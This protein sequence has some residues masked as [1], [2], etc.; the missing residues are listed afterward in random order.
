L[1]VGVRL[2]EDAVNRAIPTVV[3][4]SLVLALALAPAA[5][6]APLT[7]SIIHTVQ[8][9]E[10]LF[11][12]GLKYGVSWADI[13]QANGLSSTYIYTGQQLTIPVAG[14]V[15]PS[16]AYT[17][18]GTYTVAWGDTL[19]SIAQRFGTTT[20]EL[21]SANNLRNSS[22]IFAGQTLN[23]PGGAAATEA[24]PAV[25][26]IPVVETP[27]EP[28]TA[29]EASVVGSY[30]VRTG[31]T[32]SAIAQRN[33][34]TTTALA[35][36]NGLP[37][38]AW[39]YAGQTLTIPPGGAEEAPAPIAQAAPAVAAIHAKEILVDISDQR[40]YAY[41]DGVLLYDFIAST[42]MAGRDT[43][44]GNYSVLN[45]IPNAYGATWNIWMPNWLGIYW[46]GS[47]QNGIHALPIL[48][49]GGRLW[50]GWLG[51]PVSYGCV[52]LGIWESQSL[53]DWA[54]VGTTVTIRW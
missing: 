41:Q 10:N 30:V 54:E 19:A 53:Y 25:P 18:P 1:P 39:I 45:K 31:D 50:D 16:V 24:E 37:A 47:L 44:P 36:A 11:R 17:N 26:D 48:P 6:A 5:A 7:D 33:G 28:A 12:I 29:P 14:P 8:P 22:L 40:L 52:I 15:E 20:A 51:T 3:L 38:S 4:L 21:A 23:I 43:Q 35:S 42:G 49:G 32:L 27:P 9:G 46:A 34:L 13:M 2:E